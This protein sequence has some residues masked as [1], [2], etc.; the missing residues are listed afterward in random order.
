[1]IALGPLLS[2]LIRL[3]ETR[4][5]KRTHASIQKKVFYKG[6]PHRIMETPKILRSIGWMLAQQSQSGKS[7]PELGVV[8]QASIAS[9]DEM[10]VGG[11]GVQGYPLAIKWVQGQPGR[12][13]TCLKR[14]VYDCCCYSW[15]QEGW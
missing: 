6:L 10:E 15:S 13:R 5:T 12:M 4:K 9:T 8:T 7:S 3:S 1:M 14:P 2:G 11:S